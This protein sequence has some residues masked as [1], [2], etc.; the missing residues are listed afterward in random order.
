MEKKPTSHITKGLIIALILIALSVASY[1]TDQQQESWNRWAQ[2]L[3]LFG[4]I[5]W[6]CISYGNQMN[7]NVTFGNV[8]G[9]GFKVSAVITCITI[10]F[11][12][13]FLLLFPDLK[14]KSMELARLELEKGGS[15]ND[16]QIEQSLGLVDRMFYIFTIGVLILIYLIV[17]CIASLVGAAVTKKQPRSPFEN[18]L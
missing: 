14:E 8:F 10:V 4:G 5:I 18:Q 13:I 12:V 7:H 15:L 17:G 2:N 9:H 3:I 11:T 16:D 1:L 6:A